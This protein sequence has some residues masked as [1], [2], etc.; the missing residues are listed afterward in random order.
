M[1]VLANPTQASALSTI[2]SLTPPRR[3]VIVAAAFLGV[4]VWDILRAAGMG[5]STSYGYT[6]PNRKH[7][8]GQFMVQLP[9]VLGVS[10]AAIWDE[11]AMD[12]PSLVIQ[13][14]RGLGVKRYATEQNA[15]DRGDSARVLRLASSR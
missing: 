10:F 1:T 8:P 3:R 14:L 12:W 7:L 4:S 9:Q 15:R 5:R 2:L 6:G 11:E 13:D